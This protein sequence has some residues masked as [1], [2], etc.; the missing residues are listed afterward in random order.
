MGLSLGFS[1][2]P[3]PSRPAAMW[4]SNSTGSRFSEAVGNR[5][6]C[7]GL[8]RHA[9]PGAVAVKHCGTMD[10]NDLSNARLVHHFAGVV[11]V[12]SLWMVIELLLIS[13]ETTP[14]GALI[15]VTLPLEDGC[16]CAGDQK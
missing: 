11:L 6:R 15:V 16:Q 10:A 9:P 4:Q 12:A 13:F 14:P 8:K 2:I 1:G 3:H 5:P 7:G